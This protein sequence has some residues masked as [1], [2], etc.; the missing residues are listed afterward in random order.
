MYARLQPAFCVY[1]GSERAKMFYAERCKLNFDF[2]TPK[3]EHLLQKCARDSHRII[4][5]DTDLIP[6]RI[7]RGSDKL[8]NNDT[9]S[10]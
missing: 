10:A 2:T 7:L 9:K 4:D 6:R 5:L 3:R 8:L 1:F